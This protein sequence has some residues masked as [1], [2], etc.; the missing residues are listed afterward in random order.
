[1]TIIGTSHLKVDSKKLF[2][3]GRFGIGLSFLLSG[4][5]ILTG[6]F[7]KSDD[8]RAYYNFWQHVSPQT[9]G[10]RDTAHELENFQQKSMFEF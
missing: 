3:F 8:L 4:L 9:Y 7:S 6:Q 2:H 10:G 1:V 5:F